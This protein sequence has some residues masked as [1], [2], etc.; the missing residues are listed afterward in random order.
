M[1]L[2]ALTLTLVGHSHTLLLIAIA[3]KN[4]LKKLQIAIH[5]LLLCIIFKL[6][7]YLDRDCLS[8]DGCMFKYRSLTKEHPCIGRAPYKSAKE[9]MDALLSVSHLTTKE[10]APMSCLQQLDALEANNWTWTFIFNFGY[11][12]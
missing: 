3:L 12:L 8:V 1:E 9:G 7:T 10:V 5:V 2:H 4:T 6:Y 11:M